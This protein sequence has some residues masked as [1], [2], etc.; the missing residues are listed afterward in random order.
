MRIQIVCPH[1]E[2]DVAPTGLVISEIVRGLVA[3]GHTVDV[4]T[5]LP[6]YASHAVDEAWKGRIVRTERTAWGSISRVYPFP[7]NKRNIAARAAGFGGFTALVGL[8]SLFKRRR[9]DVVLAMSPPLTLGLAAW[10][11][12]RLRRAPLVFNVQDVFPDVAVAVGAITNRGVIRLLE[13]LERFVYRRAAVVTVLSEDLRSNVEAKLVD[14]VGPSAAAVRVRVI[15][16][17]VDTERIRPTDRDNSYRAEF[18]LG[19]R[20]VV[21]YAGNL[22]FSQPLELMVEAA[23]ELGGRDDIVFVINGEGSRRQELESLADGLDNVVF[24][25][26]QPAERLAEVLA[27]ADVHVI[28]LRRGL[29]ASSVPSKLYSILASGRPVLAALDS[30][31]EVANVVASQGAGI[32]VAAEDQSLFTAAVLELVDDADLAAMGSA[33]REFVS[34]CA[35][36]KGVAAAYSELF[37]ELGRPRA[38]RNPRWSRP[39]RRIGH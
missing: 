37:E 10:C 29:G 16:N 11:T 9:P 33:G 34:R 3:Q 15:P 38:S 5:S 23:R 27:A 22:G 39:N 26:F 7:T 13:G 20:S 25:D 6:W 28:A 24:V 36:P 18:G 8:C 2:P 21:M 17:F 14:T 1:F 32:V 12:S 30:G 35:S 31:T 19:N 4:V